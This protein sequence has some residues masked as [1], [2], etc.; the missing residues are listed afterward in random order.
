MDYQFRLTIDCNTD[1]FWDS[2]ERE[3]AR[4]LYDV[5]RRLDAGDAC[6]TFRNI[7]DTDGNIVG[8]FALKP[9]DRF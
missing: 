4:C 3:V 6:D 2:A 5:A 7:L 9:R 8:T 1:A